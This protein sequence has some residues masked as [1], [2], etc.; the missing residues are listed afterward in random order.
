M[1]KLTLNM[2]NDKIKAI[3]AVSAIAKAYGINEYIVRDGVSPSHQYFKIGWEDGDI[4]YSFGKIKTPIELEE[5]EVKDLI[6]RLKSAK[7]V[8]EKHK[9]R[10]EEVEFEI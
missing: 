9:D 6:K 2:V 3:D 5:Y 4:F 10:I 1:A 7:K 8:I